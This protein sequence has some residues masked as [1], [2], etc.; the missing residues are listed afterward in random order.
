MKYTPPEFAPLTPEMK[1]K[2]DAFARD[3][4]DDP[5]GDVGTQLLFEDDKVKIWEM[6]LEPGEHSALHRHD[7]DYY[8]AISSGD[9][10][11]GVI[12]EGGAM[13]S[14]VGVVPPA[15]NTVG[16]PKGAIEWA[17]NVGNETYREILI[18]LKDR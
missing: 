1:Q 14:F 7:H 4:A 2:L 15:G 6:V 12:P 8:L 11:A 10:V 17:W 5:L 16:L 18:E 13:D 3:H 9:L